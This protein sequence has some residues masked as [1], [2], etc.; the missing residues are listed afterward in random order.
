M[1]STFLPASSLL[2]SMRSAL[3]ATRASGT[4]GGLA[5]SHLDSMTRSGEPNYTY[6]FWLQEVTDVCP[7][8]T[9]I[10]TTTLYVDFMC[11]I[12]RLAH[13]PLFDEPDQL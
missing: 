13:T 2:A 11:R 1:D 8:P 5:T 10:G 9:L 3:T 12:A 7:T 6:F 4:S